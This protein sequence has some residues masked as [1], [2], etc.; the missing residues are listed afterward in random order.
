MTNFFHKFL[1]PHCPHCVEQE[2]EKYQDSL[3]CN[4]CE[5]LK[6][7]N[8]QLIEQN[9]LLLDKLTAKPEVE[10]HMGPP[11]ITAPRKMSM[12]WS[13]RREMLEV[14]SRERASALHSAAKPDITKV[15]ITTEEL[16]KEL[17]VVEQQRVSNV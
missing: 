4:S 9:R 13:A 1:N 14:A 5:S 15:E 3:I 12:P 17:D 8:A 11:P 7:I 10:V 2:R 6:M 16:E